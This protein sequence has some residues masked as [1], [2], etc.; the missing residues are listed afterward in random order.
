VSDNHKS[1]DTLKRIVLMCDVDSPNK[2]RGHVNM[3]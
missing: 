1:E 2:P 3:A